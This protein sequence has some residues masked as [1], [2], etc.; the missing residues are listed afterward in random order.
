MAW[1]IREMRAQTMA[2][3]RQD[4]KSRKLIKV[5]LETKTAKRIM[6]AAT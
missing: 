3:G 1:S 5:T 2:M 6:A 4:I